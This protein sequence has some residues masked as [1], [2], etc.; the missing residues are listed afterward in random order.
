MQQWQGQETPLR[1]LGKAF[2]LYADDIAH[3][4]L[5]RRWVEIIRYL[6]EQEGRSSELSQRAAGGETSR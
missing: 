5:P 4:P 1:R 2:N 6:D 3:E